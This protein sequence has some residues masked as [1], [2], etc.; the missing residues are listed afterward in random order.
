MA[1]PNSEDLALI[2]SLTR[3]L[4]QRR[5]RHDELDK[6][7][8]GERQVEMIGLAAPERLR[9]FEFPLNWCR[10]T[11]DSV[12]NRQDVRSLIRPGAEVDDEALREAWVANDMEAQASS[13]KLS[14]N[15]ITRESVGTISSGSISLIQFWGRLGP[16][17]MS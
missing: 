15:W 10:V 6:A 3:E 1:K 17:M 2:G 12:E 16:V 8:R 14:G 7:Y 9:G 5:R 13:I 4:N 11:V